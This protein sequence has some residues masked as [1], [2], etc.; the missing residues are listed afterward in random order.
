MELI[1]SVLFSTVSFI[2]GWIAAKYSFKREVSKYLGGII[3]YVDSDS[4]LLYAS[5][6]SFE[7]DIVVVEE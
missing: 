7:E 4:G 2:A 6:I 5:P 3:Y 1:L